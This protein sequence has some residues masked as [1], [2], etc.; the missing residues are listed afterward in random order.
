MQSRIE[1]GLIIWVD[2][3]LSR[4]QPIIVQQKRFVR[5]VKLKVY[6]EP[7]CPL[8]LSL[9]VLQKYLLV[10]KERYTYTEWWNNAAAILS[11]KNGKTVY[12]YTYI[13]LPWNK[14]HSSK[15]NIMTIGQDIRS[16]LWG[17]QVDTDKHRA[18][19]LKL[20]PHLVNK[21]YK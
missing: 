9:K 15:T 10:Y 1:Y 11:M 16:L 19:D 8:S 14:E 4:W 17:I 2:I 12:T 21:Q 7:S 3:Y 20:R 13:A 18:L 5:I 6:T